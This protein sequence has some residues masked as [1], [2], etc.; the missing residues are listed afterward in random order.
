M[1]KALIILSSLAVVA[2]AVFCLFYFIWTPQNMMSWGDDA[3]A[4]GRLDRAVTWYERAVNAEPE[5]IDYVFALVDANIADNNFT[6]AERNLVN[7]IK[8]APSA[9]LYAKLSS[10]YVLQ[11][12]LLDAQRMLD[13]IE[14]SSIRSEL[15]AMRP[16]MPLVTPDG[17][18]YNELITVSIESAETVYYSLTDNYPSVK[19]N[20]YAEPILLSAGTTRVQAIAV[21]E[22][23]L[24]SPL[25]DTSYLL[26]G[27]VQE[28]DFVSPELEALVREELYLSDSSPI[29]SS[30]VWKITELEIPLTVSDFTDLQY[31]EN[32][33]TL[34]I[35]N[36]VVE[37]YSFMARLFSIETLEITDSVVP[38]EAMKYIGLL[39]ELKHL[40]LARCGISDISALSSAANLVTL[41]LSQNSI[42]DISALES[43]EKLEVLNLESNAVSLLSSLTKMSA[44]SELNISRN[45]LSSL[46]PLENST[47]L[48]KLTTDDNQLMDVS[49]LLSMPKLTYFTASNNR[50]GDVSYLADCTQMTH[51]DLSNNRLT[52][53]DA[54]A[55]MTA[56][57]YLD[58]SYNSITELPELPT[59]AN[60]Q[61][62]Y[63]SNNELTNIDAL[64]G[65]PLLA[66]VNVDYNPE[67]EDILCLVDCPMLVKVDAFGTKVSD[68]QE[69]LDMSVIV[70]YDPSAVI[71]NQ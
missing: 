17:G 39:P 36:S 15:D 35:R 34:I 59:M 27:V 16:A 4:K 38:D 64:A 42:G 2:V 37:D 47:E 71:E 25:F 1:K 3:L 40:N 41:D 6:H 57:E 7:A 26:V 10:V 54:I 28:I 65:Q 70:N 56:L 5:N 8:V 14:I 21:S 53:I 51:L 23:G 43:A 18:E 62:F 45:N 68:I 30:D 44:L 52:A 60:L 19:T 46:D 63:A 32:L 29:L 48:V 69:L 50:I 12:K 11:D 24:V 22:D 33:Q 13:S 55:N 61:Y 49:V 20:L 67:L 58:I 9:A 66:Y 31:F